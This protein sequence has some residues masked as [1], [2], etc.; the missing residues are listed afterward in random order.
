MWKRAHAVFHAQLPRS[1]KDRIG[2]DSRS[3]RNSGILRTSLFI[4]YLSNMKAKEVNH[5]SSLWTRDRIEL[6]TRYGL[7]W[8]NR[9]IL[10][11]CRLSCRV[12]TREWKTKGVPCLTL[13]QH[14]HEFIFEV[15]WIME[16]T[17]FLF[18]NPHVAANFLQTTSVAP[19]VLWSRLRAC[20]QSISE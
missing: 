14:C 1:Q 11:P 10:L 19:T 12:Q 7:G 2:G 18:N 16:T 20:F 15:Y 5:T 3:H 4:N 13:E 9:V 6:R 8:P 17:Y